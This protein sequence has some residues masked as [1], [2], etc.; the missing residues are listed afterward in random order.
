MCGAYRQ[1]QQSGT[2]KAQYAGELRGKALTLV[3]PN[4][5][6]PKCFN[7]TASAYAG[8][9]THSQKSWKSSAKRHSGR[10]IGGS[11]LGIGKAEQKHSDEFLS[12]LCAVKKGQ[13]CSQRQ[14]Y[15]S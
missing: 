13:S 10:Q 8:A 14:L 3:D 11:G 9:C 5:L 2:G 6:G 4:H 15:V 7:D 1:P 12:I